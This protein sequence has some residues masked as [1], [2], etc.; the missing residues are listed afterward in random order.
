MK[1]P[2]LREVLQSLN[3]IVF[4]TATF[5]DGTMT[6]VNYIRTTLNFFFF[7]E[8]KDFFDGVEFKEMTPDGF[9]NAKLS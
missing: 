7:N 5:K 9:S 3:K 2:L 4:V 8:V 6:F 1:V